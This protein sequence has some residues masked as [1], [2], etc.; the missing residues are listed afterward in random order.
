V[1]E[2]LIPYH[3]RRPIAAESKMESCRVDI[4]AFVDNGEYYSA[5]AFVS[6]Y[7]LDNEERVYDEK[8]RIQ[9]VEYKDPAD[10]GDYSD[11]LV[12][13]P[14]TWRDDYRYD[15]AGNLLGWTRTRGE[16][17]EEFTADGALVQ[18]TDALGRATSAR[19][20]RYVPQPRQGQAP[21]LVQETGDEVLRYE[22][23]SDAD[24]VGRVKG[25]ARLEPSAAA[26]SDER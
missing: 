16:A 7:Y 11:P 10:G 12:D 14:K 8:G 20:V 9:S 6:V 26:E 19:S 2:L 18:E 22:Y 4:G 3:E 25:R 15:E 17:K 13:L 5:P 23:A 1:V 24:R 21:L